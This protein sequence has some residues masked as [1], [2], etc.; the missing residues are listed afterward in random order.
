MPRY[1]D[2]IINR[3]GKG[4]SDVPEDGYVLLQQWISTTLE[5]HISALMPLHASFRGNLRR[6]EAIPEKPTVNF[7]IED[8]PNLVIPLGAI[9][10]D[11][12]Y[13][14]VLDLIFSESQLVMCRGVNGAED[15]ETAQ[16]FQPWV[17]HLGNHEV[18]LR[19]AVEDSGLDFV[20]LG[21]G[22][23]YTPWVE[24]VRNTRSTK[25]TTRGPLIRAIPIE[26]TIL[27]GARGG[28]HD[29]AEM[30]ALRF[31]LR[32][33]ELANL[34]TRNGWDVGTDF[35][36]VKPTGPVDWVKLRREALERYEETTRMQGDFYE[37]YDI[38]CY[39]DID[40]DGIE[41][42]LYVVFDR[43]SRNLLRVSYAPEDHRPTLTYQYQRRAHLPYGLGVLEMLRPFQDT[44]TDVGNYTRLNML[45]ANCRMNVAVEGQVPEGQKIMPNGTI[46]VQ[47]STEALKPYKMA[48]VYPSAYQD[49]SFLMSLA[50][51]RSGANEL[52]MAGGGAK[53][54]NRTPGIT[55][56]TMMQQMQKRFTSAFDSIKQATSKSLVQCVW[57]YA[58]R[59]KAGDTKA[60]D[61][62]IYIMGPERGGAIVS[63][64]LNDNFD[65][66]VDVE[67]SASSA[68]INREAD[69]QNA[70]L[71]TQI[72]TSYYERTMQLAMLAANPQVTPEVKNIAMKIAEKSTEMIDRT[73]R[74]FDQVRDPATFLVHAEEELAKATQ[75]GDIQGLM[76]AIQGQVGM[77]S[78]SPQE[79]PEII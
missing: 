74:T 62:I 41:E 23:L 47:G 59:L 49:Q 9:A 53:A 79:P 4:L 19:T 48:E 76:N 40:G 22:S 60:Y 46:Y 57:R 78:S 1:V 18:E 70:M 75:G 29:I 32:K 21:T 65:D 15:T 73:I 68:S 14:Q 55:M 11:A 5:N 26:D 61:H 24:Q 58:E 16:A 64:L 56:M 50:Q 54:G 69:R 12:I 71:L 51:L 34:A 30:I 77:V 7:P 35:E 42:D 31:W 43:T 17:N 38:R 66:Q 52:S 20:Q 25:V 67:L 36:R 13:A 2:R 39:F 6:Y 10:C 28:N 37:I 72:L 44:L 8:A 3:K 45:L 27:V 63:A 33:G